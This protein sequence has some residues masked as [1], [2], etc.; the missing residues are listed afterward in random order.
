MKIAIITGVSSGLGKAFFDILVDKDFHV[1][2]I[3]RKFLDYQYKLEKNTDKVKLIM[4][5]LSDLNAV[6][7]LFDEF[8]SIPEETSEII[9]ISNAGVV[10]PVGKTGTLTPDDILYSI[11][12]NFSAPALIINYLVGMQKRRKIQG[13]YI[14]ISSGA[15]IH[16]V[17]GWG[18]YCADKAAAKMFFDC[19]EKQEQDTPDISV[20]SVNPGVMDT[21]MQDRIRET[22][23]EQFPD[24]ERYKKLKQQN[25]LQKPEDVA[26]EIL[27]DCN[28]LQAKT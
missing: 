7:A 28:V 19:L 14:N 5:D 8:N 2:G 24:V 21:Q 26:R 22:N 13:K 23:M 11:N 4:R 15:A 17:V 3:S 27:V 18:M 20:F 9:F 25:Q 6:R 1:I 12:V 10:Q 16:A